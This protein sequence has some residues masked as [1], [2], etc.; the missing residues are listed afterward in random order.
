MKFNYKIL[1]LICSIILLLSDYKTFAQKSDEP[2]TLFS[3]EVITGYGQ[4]DMK[5]TNLIKNDVLLL[6]GEGG[7]IV[8]RHF[9]IALSA[10]STVNEIAL[11]KFIPNDPSYMH[12]GYGGLK[13]GYIIAPT[14][15]FHLSV[16]LT[17]GT[18]KA[19]I[20]NRVSDEFGNESIKVNLDNSYFIYVI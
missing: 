10:H 3:S 11:D 7:V 16:P 6:G 5:Y 17:F 13:F 1:A 9:Q 15:L 14:K 12:I 8:N 20:Y 19:D 18:G 4:F 2:T